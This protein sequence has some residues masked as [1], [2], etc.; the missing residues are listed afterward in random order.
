MNLNI[1]LFK[2][3]GIALAPQRGRILIAEPF[4]NDTYF[5]R[6]VVLLTE[7]TSEG[8]VG[9]VLNKPVEISVADIL[10]GFPDFG[11]NVTLGGPV[12][13][14]TVHYLHT[15][16][17]LIPNSVEVVPGVF[18]GGDFDAVKNLIVS[19]RM[20][21]ADIRFFIGYSGWRANQLEEELEQNA[22]AVS[23]INPS[24]IME[25]HDQNSWQKVLESLGSKYR[26]WIN[27][28]ENPGLN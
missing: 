14:N 15:L 9:F 20:G 2:I 4:L 12:Q 1:D 27:T 17:E 26:I 19:G 18:W 10:D 6:S 21:I 16:G 11:A 23:D 8:T 7:H 28:P 25:V 3:E 22:W 5:K 13:T 24:H